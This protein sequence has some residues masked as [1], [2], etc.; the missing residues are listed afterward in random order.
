MLPV[1]VFPSQLRGAAQAQPK[2][3]LL[4]SLPH[5]NTRVQDRTQRC[6]GQ[7]LFQGH[8]D[9]RGSTFSWA[10]LISPPEWSL[11]G[12]DL[13]SPWVLPPL[14]PTLLANLTSHPL[15]AGPDGRGAVAPLSPCRLLSLKALPKENPGSHCSIL[16]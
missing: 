6:P 2:L 5:R 3:C 9:G 4:Q 12:W 1:P 14:T 11:V 10:L 15:L 8:G 16:V 7:E 13:R